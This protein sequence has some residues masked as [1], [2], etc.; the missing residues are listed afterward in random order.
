MATKKR[1]FIGFDYDH[2]E[3]AKIMLA[4]RAKLPDSPFDFTD[5]SVKDHLSGDWKNKVLQVIA[6]LRNHRDR[7]AVQAT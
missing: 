7:P 3:A 4:G 6:G 2:D 1:V 5:T